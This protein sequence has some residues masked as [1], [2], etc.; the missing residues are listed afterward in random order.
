MRAS[1]AQQTADYIEGL[2][3]G[4]GQGAGGPFRLAERWGEGDLC[5]AL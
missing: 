1:L 4:Q 5:D 3:L 2:T